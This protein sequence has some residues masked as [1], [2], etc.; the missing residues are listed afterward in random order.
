MK[1]CDPALRPRALPQGKRVHFD[2]KSRTVVD[3][4][5]KLGISLPGIWSLGVC[6]RWKRPSL[7]VIALPEPLCPYRRKIEIRQRI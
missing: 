6:L 4:P 7:W 5:F 1:D 2:G 3:G